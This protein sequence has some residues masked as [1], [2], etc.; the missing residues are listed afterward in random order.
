MI[1]LA[2]RTDATSLRDND[3]ANEKIR[4]HDAY[5]AAPM[6][7]GMISVMLLSLLILPVIY[8]LVLQ[9]QERVPKTIAY[10]PDVP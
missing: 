6:V 4:S 5:H 7:G 3:T 8:G 2:K 1:L 10:E 9:V